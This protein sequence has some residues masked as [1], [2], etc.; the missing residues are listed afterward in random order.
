MAEASSERI[1]I[2]GVGAI[3]SLG[4]SAA[5]TTA[6]VRAGVSGAMLSDLVDGVGDRVSIAALSWADLPLMELPVTLPLR[7]QEIVRLA[8]GALTDV[9]QGL[10]AEYPALP[11]WGVWPERSAGVPLDNSRCAALLGP[12]FISQQTLRGAAGSLQAVAEAASWIQM[13]GGLAV[14]VAADS[15]VHPYILATL[16]A[17]GRVKTKRQAEG[18]IPGQ[19]A[20]ALLL[21]DSATVARLGLPRLATIGGS[22][23]ATDPLPEPRGD[24]LSAA[25][26]LALNGTDTLVNAWWTTFSGERAYAQEHSTACI[27]SSDRCDKRHEVHHPAMYLG[28]TGAAAALL[29]TVCTV[30]RPTRPAL[31][32]ATADGAQ[33]AALLVL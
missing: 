9:V 12:R 1:V 2:C 15:L 4:L 14:V 3:S 26:R 13:S 24:G 22:G 30:S 19:G 25:I 32:C 20:A 18:L 29:A 31:I 6:Q 16:L 21:G 27:R 11:T 33:R 8:V 10:P 23:S 7:E 17:E 28:D 5:Q